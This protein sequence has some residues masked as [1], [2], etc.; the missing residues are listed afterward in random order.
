MSQGTSAAH[1]RLTAWQLARKAGISIIGFAL[2]AV[3]MSL[4]IPELVDEKEAKEDIAGL[5]FTGSGG[6]SK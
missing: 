4:V 1:A 2:V 3:G 6:T 5:A